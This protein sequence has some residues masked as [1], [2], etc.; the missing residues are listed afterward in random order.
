[1]TLPA[2]SR[3]KKQLSGIEVE[4]TRQIANVCIHVERVNGNVRKKYS[5]LSLCQPID[6]LSR[7]PDDDVTTLDKIVTVACTLNNLCNSVVPSD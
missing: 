4:Q 5:L 1:M 7:K 6:F 2:V 3:G